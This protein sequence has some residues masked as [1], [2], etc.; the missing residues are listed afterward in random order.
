[1]ADEYLLVRFNRL[2]TAVLAFGGRSRGRRWVRCWGRRLRARGSFFGQRARWFYEGIPFALGGGPSGM[3]LL[4]QSDAE[5]HGSQ[6][7]PATLCLRIVGSVFCARLP[8]RT[9]P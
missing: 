7:T 3:E 5:G 8:L 1:M 9:F 6:G 4:W 2:A